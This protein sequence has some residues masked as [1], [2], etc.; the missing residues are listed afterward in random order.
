MVF[1]PVGPTTIPSGFSVPVPAKA[2]PVA[3]GVPGEVRRAEREAPGTRPIP[4][5]EFGVLRR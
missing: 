4:E 2:V 5:F 3:A 1:R